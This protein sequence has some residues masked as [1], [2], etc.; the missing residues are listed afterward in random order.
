ML[1]LI[2]V[3][4]MQR[5]GLSYEN[6]TILDPRDGSVYKA[7]MELSPDG[8]KLSVRGYLGVPLLGQSQVWRRLPDNAMQPAAGSPNTNKPPSGSATRPQ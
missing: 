7:S 2:I 5:K 4:G 6:G 1:D 8:Q 3:N